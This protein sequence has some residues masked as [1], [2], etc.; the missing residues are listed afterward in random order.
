[1]DQGC[2]IIP[3]GPAPACRYV[4]ISMSTDLGSSPGTGMPATYCWRGGRGPSQ[5]AGMCMIRE[6]LASVPADEC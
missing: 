6:P 5:R 2:A 3:T 4:P 1:M